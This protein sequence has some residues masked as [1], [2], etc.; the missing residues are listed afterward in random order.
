MSIG[1]YKDKS[2][3]QY[4]GEWRSRNKD[5]WKHHDAYEETKTKRCLHCKSVLK[6]KCFYKSVADID[7][8]QSWCIG[9][10]KKRYRKDPIRQLLVNAKSRAKKAGMEF[11]LN[12]E[13]VLIPD[14]CPVLGI[15]IAIGDR[16]RY[17]NSPSLDRVDNSRGY[18]PDN[19]LVIS[20][21]ANTLK[22]DAQ[23]EELEKVIVY[24]KEHQ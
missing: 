20:W 22:R 14:T 13:D 4:M 8:L 7:G 15:P 12:R 21:R 6:S 23:I 10:L 11:S 17:D 24:M 18:T 1:R 3:E 19:V 16:G 9:C 5:H 2:P